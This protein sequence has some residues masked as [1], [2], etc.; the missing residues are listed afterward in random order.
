M[1]FSAVICPSNYHS[2]RETIALR[3]SDPVHHTLPFSTSRSVLSNILLWL[4]GR[5]TP[6]YVITCSERHLVCSRNSRPDRAHMSTAKH[7][8]KRDG[9]VES[10]VRRSPRLLLL[11]SANR[12]GSHCDGSV[13]V[14]FR[15]VSELFGSIKRPKVSW[16][17]TGFHQECRASQQLKALNIPQKRPKFDQ[18]HKAPGQRS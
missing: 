3:F 1:P 6:E 17:C 12:A 16:G 2:F 15:P 9:H 11:L 4:H 8:I 14:M 18:I 13:P 7:E 10:Q 5:G